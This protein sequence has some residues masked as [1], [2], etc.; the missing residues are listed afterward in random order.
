MEGWE[1]REAWRVDRVATG[2]AYVTIV[3]AVF[4]DLVVAIFIGVVLSLLLYSI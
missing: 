4:V 2:A 3:V 1:L